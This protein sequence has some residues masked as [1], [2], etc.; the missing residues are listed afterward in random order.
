MISLSKIFVVILCGGL[1]KR[2]RKVV[3]DRPKPMADI[4][5][6][7]FLDI[8]IKHLISCGIRNI[9]LAAGYKSEKIEEYYKNKNWEVKI[10][11]EIKIY[12]SKEKKLLGTGGAVKNVEKYI[13]SNPFIVLNGDT[14]C[15]IDYRKLLN[16]HIKKGAVATVVVTKKRNSL[17]VGF[18]KM[19]EHNKKIIEFQEKQKENFDSKYVNVGIYV[20]N[21]TIFKLIPKNKKCSLEYDVF[22]K[23]RNIFGYN[24]N[25]KFID[26]G[27]PERYKLAKEW[28]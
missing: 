2:L 27:T 16:W 20:F 5:G 17:D 8:V 10:K 7:P 3:S 12:V 6:K 22:P 1:G 23:I 9:V 18:I 15:K 26:I 25:K 19:D 28:L 13:K 4:N 11:K 21:K 24:T 14:F